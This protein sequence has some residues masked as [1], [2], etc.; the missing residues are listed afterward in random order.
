MPQR[1]HQLQQLH[2]P[3]RVEVRVIDRHHEERPRLLRPPALPVVLEL[4]DKPPEALPR[5]QPLTLRLLHLHGVL[6]GIDVRTSPL[7]APVPLQRRGLNEP[8]PPS[9]RRKLVSLRRRPRYRRRRSIHPTPLHRTHDPLEHPGEPCG[10][11]RRLRH[12]LKIEQAHGNDRHTFLH[13]RRRELL[14][15]GLALELLAPVLEQPQHH[16]RL[17]RAARAVDQYG[18]VATAGIEVGQ[19]AVELRRASRGCG[20]QARHADEQLVR[21]QGRLVLLRVQLP[22]VRALGVLGPV[23]DAGFLPGLAPG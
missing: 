20:H 5:V 9:P 1:P 18:M 3:R 23:Q 6:L 4:I 14:R 7:Q 19:K 17:A 22:R 13:R 15:E 12:P 16:A 21:L 2:Q 10:E 8:P 11:V